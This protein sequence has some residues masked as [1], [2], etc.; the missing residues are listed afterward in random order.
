[1]GQGTHAAIRFRC[2]DWSENP[3]RSAQSVQ[4]GR[5][6]LGGAFNVHDKPLR[7]GQV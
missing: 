7:H 5:G 1:M 6:L 3:V 2:S 4:L